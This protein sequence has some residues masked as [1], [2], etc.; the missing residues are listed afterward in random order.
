M[1]LDS[2]VFTSAGGREH[3][4]D[5]AAK[6][7]FSSPAP[8]GGIYVV[9]DGLGGHQY[10]ERASACAVETLTAAEAP[11]AEEDGEAWLRAQLET[12]NTRILAQQRETQAVMKSTA[13]VLLIR[14]ERAEWANVGD[15]RL[16]Y[17]HGRE[18]TGVT[19]DHS[20][21]YKKY[22]AG[23]ISRDMIGT[24]EDQSSLLRALGNPE[25]HEPSFYSSA[26]PL[27]PGDGFLLCS[28]GVW[29]YLP[30]GEILIDFLKAGNARQ[31]AELLLLRVISRVQPG[32]DNL[33]LITV[34]VGGDPD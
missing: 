11:A 34:M 32:N 18:L 20:V 5:A 14:G 2:Y 21:A 26:A 25:R 3:N 16:Y 28:D 6:R 29:E 8:A 27:S 4:E 10:G 17:L 9:A 1:R 23:E 15:S 12:A 13:V 22:K 31:W 33:S 19:E 7:E 30:D 24:D